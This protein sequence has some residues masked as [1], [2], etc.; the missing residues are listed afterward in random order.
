MEPDCQ[1]VHVWH[2]GDRACHA[3]NSGNVRHACLL[4]LAGGRGVHERGLHRLR[5]DAAH[6]GQGAALPAHYFAGPALIHVLLV[7]DVLQRV[8]WSAGAGIA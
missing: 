5:D 7:D 3:G 2:K 8:P 1:A 4:L 6:C